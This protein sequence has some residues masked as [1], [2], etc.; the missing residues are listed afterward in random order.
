[1]KHC[2]ITLFCVFFLISCGRD[3]DD[4][5]NVIGEF[6]PPIEL[7]GER[8]LKNE[9][10]IL[11]VYSAYSYII[12]STIRDTL[13]HIYD[14]NMKYLGGFGKQGQG[15][16][17]FPQ[18]GLIRDAI[19]HRESI[20][21]CA[22]D[23]ARHNNYG[24][25]L[26]STLESGEVVVAHEYELPWDLH[27][28]YLSFYVDENT[29]IGTYR[30]HFYQRLDGNFG[31]FYN[32][33]ETD[34]IEIYPL[35]KLDIYSNDGQPVNDPS[36]IMNINSHAS[37]ISPDR[38]KFAVQLMYTPRL[39]VFTIG[40][41]HPSRFLLK[42]KPPKEDFD[43]ESIRQFTAPK[44]YNEIQ[45][46]D[47]FIYLLYSGHSEADDEIYQLEKIVQVIDWDGNPHNQFLIPAQYDITLFTVDEENGYFYGLSH[48]TDTIYRFEY[49]SLFSEF[50][51]NN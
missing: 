31:L 8:I 37:A 15:P 51:M 49:G 5:W 48:T 32:F 21:V 41:P 26:L 45:A 36:A 1:M 29:V 35:Y 13:F 6:P 43:L 11:N 25:D 30:D 34:S 42:A 50:S 20:I 2:I 3:Y 12:T 47:N 18:I 27:G 39:E 19:K 46:T 24:I 4:T 9:F 16:F 23:P 40:Y 22:I 7:Q 38:S 28:A 17:E 10:G 44:Y 33:Q 14:E